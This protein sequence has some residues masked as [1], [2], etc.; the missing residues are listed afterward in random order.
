MRTIAYDFEWRQ[1]E[2]DEENK[3]SLLK[4]NLLWKMFSDFMEEIGP[5]LSQFFTF[6]SAKW[7][8]RNESL[9]NIVF[10]FA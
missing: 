3:E 5:I 2:W 6:I 4:E 10:L 9:P 7:W 1:D 8:S